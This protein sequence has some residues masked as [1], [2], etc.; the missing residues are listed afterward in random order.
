MDL[1]IYS[2]HVFH[3]FDTAE[4]RSM[5]NDLFIVRSNYFS[6]CI[7]R[8]FVE[9]AYIYK[10]LDHF[11]FFRNAENFVCLRAKIVGYSSDRVALVNGERNDRS[12]GFIAAYK[13]NISTM[14]SRD[15]GN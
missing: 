13:R 7:Y 3:S 5:G 2:Y 6:E 4:I 8:F 11:N 12:K 9:P 15:N 14:Q 10:I 1:R